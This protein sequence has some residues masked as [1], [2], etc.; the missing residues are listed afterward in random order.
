MLLKAIGYGTEDILTMFYDWDTYIIEGPLVYLRVN[1]DTLIGQRA[2]L[3]VVNPETGDILVRKNRKFS[4]TMM[5]KFEELG[6][7]RI[8]VEQDDIAFWE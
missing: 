5:K 8:P 1:P 7:E 3:D 2:T 6:V 4:R